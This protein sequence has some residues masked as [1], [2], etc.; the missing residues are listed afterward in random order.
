MRGYTYLG[1]H[2]AGSTPAGVVLTQ[3]V[4]EQIRAAASTIH[5]GRLI[6]HLDAERKSVDIELQT[7]ERVEL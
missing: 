3:K 2:M 1:R 4:L 7:R 5:H 6:I